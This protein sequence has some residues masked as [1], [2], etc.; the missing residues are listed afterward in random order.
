MKNS[1]LA[2]W[3]LADSV[4]IIGYVSLIAYI[5]FN[6]ERLFGQVDNFTGPLL[7]LTLFIVS[8]V[9]TGG[10]FLGRPIYLYFEGLKKEA[11]KLFF[12]TL[13]F[14]ILIALVILVIRI[15]L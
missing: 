7:F 3:A 6:G 9:I 13:G 12:Y 1:K 14:L 15:L 8:A 4:G 11:I 5:I 10:L 2:F